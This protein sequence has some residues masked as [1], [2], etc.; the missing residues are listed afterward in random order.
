MHHERLDGSGYPEKKMASDTPVIARTLALVDT[1]DALVAIDRP[2]RKALSHSKVIEYLGE[3]V[4]KDFYDNTV[5]Q[6]L[7][8]L[9]RSLLKDLYG[10]R[11]FDETP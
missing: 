1:Y 7:K 8:R 3:E 5:Y 10:D 2:Y 4:K 11:I 6:A 9:D